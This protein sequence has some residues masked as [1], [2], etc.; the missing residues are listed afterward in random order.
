[1]QRWRASPSSWT[2]SSPTDDRVVCRWRARTRHIGEFAEF[3][4]TGNEIEFP[5]LSLWEFDHGKARRGWS[6][7][8]L[9]SVIGQLQD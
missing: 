3:S 4:A 9:V 7:F 2:I 6:C 8:D 1:M 5:G